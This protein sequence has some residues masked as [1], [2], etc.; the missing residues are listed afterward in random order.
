MQQL[1]L[2]I[3]FPG[4]KAWLGGLPI[5]LRSDRSVGL[6]R[7]TFI[8]STSCYMSF[9]RKNRW[10]PL[11]VW[12]FEAHHEPANSGETVKLTF[13][14]EKVLVSE[15]PVLPGTH[16]P[17]TTTDRSMIDLI[18][19]KPEKKHAASSVVVL[20]PS[21]LQESQPNLVLRVKKK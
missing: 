20:L 5:R 2:S 21:L 18:R 7:T 16:P 14:C 13:A 15:I 17:T 4:M 8:H 6:I 12:A 3:V 9:T 19:R 10:N 1:K 11:L